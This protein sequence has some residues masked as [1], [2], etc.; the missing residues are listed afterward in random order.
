VASVGAP[1]RA[2]FAVGV[3]VFVCGLASLVRAERYYGSNLRGWDAQFY[4][5]AARSLVFDRDLDVT[6][7]LEATP[8]ALPFDRDRDGR[9]EMAPRNVSGRILSKYPIGLSLI[10]TP[11]L[12]LGRALRGALAAAGS[13]SPRPPGYSRVEIWTVNVGLLLVIAFGAQVL[14]DLLRPHVPA[15]WRELSLA[16]AFLGT[17]L[18]YYASVFPFMTHAVGFA[19]VVWTVRISQSVANG[20]HRLLPLLGFALGALFLVRPQQLALAL[21][22][23]II[24]AALRTQPV[25]RWLPWAAAGGV[26][27]AALVALQAWAN[28]RLIGAW[29]LDAYAA[30]GARFDWRRLALWT[31]LISPTRG[32]FWMSPVVLLAAA[33][34]ATT[35]LRQ[36]PAGFSVF[37][38]HALIQVYLIANWVSPGQG[39]SF[40]A[41]MFVESAA[42]VACGVGLMYRHGALA[43]NLFLTAAVVACLA[44]TNRLMTLYN[45]GFLLPQL[46]HGQCLDLVSGAAFRPR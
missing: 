9:F 44:W 17:S 27:L 16:A 19:L 21:P 20:D 3:V 34:Y 24:L 43:R 23:L 36:L 25:E 37:A 32:L 29:T 5:A 7:D 42:F 1:G 12:A 41:R 28:T 11:F 14:C 30:S 46:T 18:F 4:Y 10:E 26:V 22:L 38:V 13:T 2:R 15:P 6:N 31:V 45:A 35:P 33:G 39:D 40:G 8:F